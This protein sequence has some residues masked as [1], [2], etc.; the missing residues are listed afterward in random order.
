MS[1]NNQRQQEA[2]PKTAEE[3]IPL[4]R[5]YFSHEFPNSGERCPSPDEIVELIESG[6]LPDDSLRGHLLTCSRCFVTYKE[7]LQKSRDMQPIIA[8]VRQHRFAFAHY[9]WLRI[10]V[11]SLPIL[12]I[13]AIAVI[14]FR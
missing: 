13:A 4:A 11:P 12:L 9:P 7:R 2:V 3:L 10:L 14:Y 6:T 1:D 5:E 8:P